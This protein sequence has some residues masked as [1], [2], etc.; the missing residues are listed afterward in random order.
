KG[1]PRP[2][3]IKERPDIRVHVR[4]HKDIAIL[5]VDMVGSGLHQRGD[6]PESG[7]APRRETLAAAILLRGGWD[8]HQ[9]L[10]DPLWGS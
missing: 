6:R 5:C 4:L 2:N 10:L 7:R 9:P 8:G 3:I 1:L